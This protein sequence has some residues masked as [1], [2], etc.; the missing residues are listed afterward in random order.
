MAGVC[1]P[2]APPAD[3][4]VVGERVPACGL[5]RPAIEQVAEA[6]ERAPPVDGGAQP[7]GDR[8]IVDR[9]DEIIHVA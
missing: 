1:E 6:T 2:G 5:L 4:T 8:G 7:I 9:G 3:L